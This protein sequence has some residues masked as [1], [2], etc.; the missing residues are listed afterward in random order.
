MLK[1][2]EFSLLSGI[3]IPMLRN[4]NKLGLLVPSLVDDMNGYR[5]YDK[6]QLMI[7][8]QIVAMKSMGFGLDEIKH[9][10]QLNHEELQ[11]LFKKKI[12][13]KELE[14][15]KIADQ[16]DSLRKTSFLEN[17]DDT[18]IALRIVTKTQPKTYALGYQMEIH[19]YHEEGLLWA[20]INKQIAL[21]HLPIPEDATAISIM[22]SRDVDNDTILAEIMLYI[23]QKLEHVE[24]LFLKEI[25]AHEVVS[26]LFRGSYVQLHQINLI[27]AKWLETS[28]Y[29]LV[30]EPYIIYHKSPKNT[31]LESSYLSEL[32]FP[33][34]TK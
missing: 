4:Y 34:E 11:T 2:G 27:L 21:Q 26:V 1:I 9:S 18:Q 6:S 3:S 31:N 8:N 14:Q 22:H 29:E 7:A 12:K 5:Y 10:F 17:Y 23:P 32:C 28:N 19:Q 20:E 25:K 13:E 15:R 16:L 24:P 33:I 30:S